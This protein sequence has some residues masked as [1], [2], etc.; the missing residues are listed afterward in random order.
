MRRL[1][2][3]SLFYFMLCVVYKDIKKGMAYMC[4]RVE[5]SPPTP[6]TPLPR[7]MDSSARGI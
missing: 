5:E 1:E 6:T 4:V 2:K 7:T 3:S